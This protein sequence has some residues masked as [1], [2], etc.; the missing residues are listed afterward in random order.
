MEVR[1]L[2]LKFK[3][4]RIALG[5]S[6]TGNVEGYATVQNVIEIPFSDIGS[7]KVNI[8]LLNG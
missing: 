2:H 7:M 5:N 8:E 3:G 6:D 1:T 4:T